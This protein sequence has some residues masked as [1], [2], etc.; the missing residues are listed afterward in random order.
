MA[1]DSRGRRGPVSGFAGHHQTGQA[2]ATRMYVA[3]SRPTAPGSGYGMLAAI[4]R[5]EPPWL[6]WG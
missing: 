2:P 4:W 6:M 3:D 1:A 5:G